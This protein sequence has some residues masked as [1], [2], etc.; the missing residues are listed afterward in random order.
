[1]VLTPVVLISL[2]DIRERNSPAF[3]QLTREPES[4]VQIP[5][6]LFAAS[7]GLPVEEG[8]QVGGGGPQIRGTWLS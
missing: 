6:S 2:P 7:S 3:V 4:D 1:M 5:I 8:D